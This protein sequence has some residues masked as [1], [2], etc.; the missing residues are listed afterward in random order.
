MID[1]GLA[2]FWCDGMLAHTF[3]G[4]GV[5][6]AAALY[7]IY[8]LRETADGPMVIFAVSDSE[9]HGMARALKR[10]D[11]IEDPRFT[12]LGDRIQNIEVLEEIINSEFAKWPAVELVE[13]LV[14]EDVPAGPVHSLE[15]V[16]TDPQIAHNESI[17]EYDHPHAGRIRQP[18]PAAKFDRTQA[19]VGRPPPMLGEHTDEVLG[20]LGLDSGTVAKL[21][22]GGVVS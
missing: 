16:I 20:E 8:K 17:V 4:D 21:R 1:A 2:F 19:S 3:V 6:P 10:E 12:T 18:A 15:E 14:A 7:D 9:F 13:R 22:D 11:L 5:E